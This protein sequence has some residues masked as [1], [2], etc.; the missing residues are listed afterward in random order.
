M[1]EV[2]WTRQALRNL[3]SITAY[4]A[5]DNPEAAKKFS[6]TVFD[7]VEHLAQ[8]PAVGRP[9]RVL[10]TRELIVHENYLVPYRGKGDCV[11]ILRVQHVKRRPPEKWRT[12]E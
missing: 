7:R 8:F 10:R 3:E 4:I 5:R 9:G 12:G 2:R 6:D 11:D 1:F